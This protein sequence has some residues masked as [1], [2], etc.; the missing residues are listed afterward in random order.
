MKPRPP[1]RDRNTG[2]DCPDRKPG[3]HDTCGAYR[4]FALKMKEWNKQRQREEL[5]Y[6]VLFDEMERMKKRRSK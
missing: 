3:C 5:S 1:C 6:R 4:E 2:T